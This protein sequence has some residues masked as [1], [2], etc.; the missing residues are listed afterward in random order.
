MGGCTHRPW[1][2]FAPPRMGQLCRQGARTIE[3]GAR[4]PAQT[5]PAPPA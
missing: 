4:V 3:A 5:V 2:G 1:V